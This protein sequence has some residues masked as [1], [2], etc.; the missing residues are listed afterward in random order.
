M[1]NEYSGSKHSSSK[2]TQNS[3]KLADVHLIDNL[4]GLDPIIVYRYIII[5]LEIHK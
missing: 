4:V 5:E 2:R 3:E 1:F